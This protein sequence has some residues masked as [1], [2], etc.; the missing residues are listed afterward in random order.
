MKVV[1]L[2]IRCNDTEAKCIEDKL[3]DFVLSKSMPGYND[4]NCFHTH[5][6]EEKTCTLPTATSTAAS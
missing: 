4:P 2:K 3:H 6:Y 5:I 1:V